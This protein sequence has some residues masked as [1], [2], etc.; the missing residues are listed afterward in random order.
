[1]TVP[2]LTVGEATP[3]FR[4]ATSFITISLGGEEAAM[5]VLRWT[6]AGLVL[7]ALAGIAAGLFRSHPPSAYSQTYTSLTED[8]TDDPDT[9]ARPGG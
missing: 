2:L 4:R 8:T 7:G 5:R 1:M 9:A 3:V 6:L